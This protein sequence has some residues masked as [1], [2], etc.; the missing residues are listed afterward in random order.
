M[1]ANEETPEGAVAYDETYVRERLVANGLQIVD[2]IHY[3]SWCG[4]QRFL[5]YQDLMIV[6]RLPVAN[7]L[8]KE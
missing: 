6:E 1:I 3:G 7:A 2:H 8:G 4:R 5:S